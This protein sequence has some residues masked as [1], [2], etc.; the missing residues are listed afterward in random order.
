MKALRKVVA[1]L[2]IAMMTIAFC[3]CGDSGS[4]S[5]SADNSP[6]T[7]DEISALYTDADSFK[8]SFL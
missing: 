1:L 7:E 6:I 3:A 2:M 5:E 8:G 4:S